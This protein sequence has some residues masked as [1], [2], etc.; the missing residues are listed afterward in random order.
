MTVRLADAP[1]SSD[2]DVEHPDRR[3]TPANIP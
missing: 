2:F 3:T 1:T